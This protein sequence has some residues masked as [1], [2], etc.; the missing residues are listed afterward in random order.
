M[1]YT[2]KDA[3][4]G[5]LSLY[6]AEE[7]R[8]RGGVV[9]MRF[10]AIVSNESCASYKVKSNVPILNF[11]SVLSEIESA[12][13]PHDEFCGHT[14]L[15]GNVLVV[16]EWREINNLEKEFPSMCRLFIRKV[17]SRNMSWT[18]SCDL[19]R[20]YLSSH[21]T[22][23]LNSLNIADVTN[24]PPINESK[25]SQQFNLDDG[26]KESVTDD[27]WTRVNSDDF[28]GQSDEGWEILTVASSSNS[29]DD[30]V[31]VSAPEGHNR[32]HNRQRNKISYKD[33]LLASQGQPQARTCSYSS[34][35]T[36]PSTSRTWSPTI[37][38]QPVLKRRAGREYVRDISTKSAS[39]FGNYYLSFFTPFD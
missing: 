6:S 34:N 3:Y 1:Q 9:Y 2:S 30:H 13:K 37:Q 19:I 35:G 18:A 7:R 27:E 31:V 23:S 14:P 20:S 15:R 5:C 39:P 11:E 28:Q 24:W 16:A 29:I 25:V 26:E 32:E 33:A 36:K 38:I 12:R 8:Q 17:Y 21:G 10:D 22:R 4:N